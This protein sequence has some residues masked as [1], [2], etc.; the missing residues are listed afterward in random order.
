MRKETNKM[1]LKKQQKYAKTVEKYHKT[2]P[3]LM[4]LR[5]LNRQFRIKPFPGL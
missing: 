5:E 3:K 2:N 1:S 4:R